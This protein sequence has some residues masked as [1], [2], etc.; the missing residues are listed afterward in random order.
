MP[1]ISAIVPTRD[2]PQMA[3]E[4]VEAILH[5]TLPPSELIIAD[6]GDGAVGAELARQYGIKQ[7]H[8]AGRGPAEARN[9]AV[10]LSTGEWLAF[11]DDD[12]LW[13]PDRLARQAEYIND[14]NTVLIYADARRDDGGSVLEGRKAATGQVFTQ[15]LLDNWVPTSTVLLRRTAFEKSGGFKNRFCPAEDYR[16]WLRISRLGALQ[17]IDE[18]LAVYRIHAGQ[19][20]TITAEMAG[21]TANV[22]LDALAE[23]GW[24]AGQVSGLSRRLRQ[25]RFVQGRALAAQ[26][27]WSAARQAYLQ[28][29][30]HQLTYTQAP[31]FWL[32]SFFGK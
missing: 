11:C 29:W 2:R 15:L 26:Q 28:A 19:L 9:A 27:K 18:P 1:S 20:Q 30:Q 12:D 4:A 7:I 6:D 17:K 14:S 5:Q 3:R 31:L 24:D 13:L 32:L 21:S 10:K 25:L 23:A 16:L 22:I 8:T